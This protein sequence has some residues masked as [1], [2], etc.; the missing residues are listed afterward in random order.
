TWY[1]RSRSK[2]FQTYFESGFPHGK[3][4]FI[5]L[6]ASSWATTA[7]ALALPEN[8]PASKADQ[9]P[10]RKRRT[11]VAIVKDAFRINGRPTYQGRYWNGKRIEGLLFNARL[12]QGI[13][14]DLNPKTRGLW[15]YPDTKKWDPERNTRE[16]LAAMPRW[17]KHGLLAFTLNLQGGNP[18]GYGK[19]QP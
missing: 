2:P 8:P 1:V 16:F 12:V 11:E 9:Q 10:A 3:D 4:Q 7:L 5:S 6:A 19:D 14:D 13:F 18:Q 17:R 15:A